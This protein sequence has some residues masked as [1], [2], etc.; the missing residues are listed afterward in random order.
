MDSGQ[1]DYF[2]QTLTL[3]LER[4]WQMN[5][6]KPETPWGYVILGMLA[7]LGVLIIIWIWE[8]HNVR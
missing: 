1:P 2:N 6:P 4:T 3:R 7:G 8:A 5:K